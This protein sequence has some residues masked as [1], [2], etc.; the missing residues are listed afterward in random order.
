MQSKA[1]ER[2]VDTT[3]TKKL[4]SKFSFH[5]STIFMSS[6]LVLF[7]FLFAAK[8]VKKTFIFQ[9]PKNLL[10]TFHTFLR[11]YSK[12]WLVGLFSVFLSRG[13]TQ[14]TLALLSKIFYL[15]LLFI[16]IESGALKASSAILIK[17]GGILSSAIAFLPFSYRSR[18]R[19]SSLITGENIVLSLIFTF[20][21]NITFY[22]YYARMVSIWI[23][24]ELNSLFIVI[25]SM[26]FGYVSRFLTTGFLNNVYIDFDGYVFPKPAIHRIG[27]APNILCPRCKELFE[28]HL[29]SLLLLNWVQKKP[30][31]RTGTLF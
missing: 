9:N 10:K 17:A 11:K 22:F 28:C 13:L 20:S 19:T 24:Y 14:A 6:C 8:K 29:V 21:C 3:P 23:A 4:L 2:S 7:D 16:A 27:N 18:S 15:K 31:W 1:F 30:F 25:Y 26:T 5:S 12:Y